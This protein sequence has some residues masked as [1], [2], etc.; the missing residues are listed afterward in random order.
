MTVSYW[1]MVGALVNRG[2]MHPEL[3]FD[4]TGEDIVTWDRC[5]AW[6]DEARADLRPN[7]LHE[8]ETLAT[9]HLAYR[10]RKVQA[11]VEARQ[12]KAAAAARPRARRAR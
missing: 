4:H 6:I 11:Y 10:T 1:E 3:F 9:N 12:P 2:V 7:Y 5:K 8:F